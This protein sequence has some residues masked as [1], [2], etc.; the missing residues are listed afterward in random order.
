MTTKLPCTFELDIRRWW[1]TPMFQRRLQVYH[2]KV[3][4]VS[5][6][7][8]AGCGCKCGGPDAFY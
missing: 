6:C 4:R 8:G 5:G 2:T 3:V 1:Q 7:F